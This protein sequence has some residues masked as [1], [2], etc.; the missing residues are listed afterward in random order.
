MAEKE[1]PDAAKFPSSDIGY[2]IKNWLNIH[3]FLNDSTYDKNFSKIYYNPL[4]TGGYRV[5]NDPFEK[6]LL[7]PDE[8]F[9]YEFENISV[10]KIVILLGVPKVGLDGASIF[11][12][13]FDAMIDWGHPEITGQGGLYQ[14]SVK[15]CEDY[16]IQWGVIKNNNETVRIEFNPNK[17]DLKYLMAFFSVFKKQAFSLARVTRLDVAIDYG[18]YLNPHCWAVKNT[19]YSASFEFNSVTKTRYFGSPSSDVQI[20]IY[21]KKKEFLDHQEINLPCSDFWR[22]EA[23]VKAIGGDSFFLHEQKKVTSFNP[24]ERLE[25]FD[26]FCFDYED[27]GMFSL[28]CECVKSRGMMWAIRQ[29]GSHNTSSKYKEKFKFLQGDL[30]FNLPADIYKN[31]FGVVYGRF[32]NQ[33]RELFFEGQKLGTQVFSSI[34]NMDK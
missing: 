18:I 21:D 9:L 28:F 23:Q 15:W 2:Q 30:K 1:I 3:A 17:C 5:K 32:V 25:F 6:N 19:P 22:C 34:N 14:Y 13:R 4:L 8:F 29:L 26:P 33:L 27:M 12:K 10:D 24:F 20:R 7:N 11:W 31:C 16:F